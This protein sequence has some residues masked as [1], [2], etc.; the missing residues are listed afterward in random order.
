VIGCRRTSGAVGAAA[1]LQETVICGRCSMVAKGKKSAKRRT[2]A[3]RFGPAGWSYDDWAGVVYPRPKPR[4]FDPLQALATYFDTIEVNT[5]FYRPQRDSVARSWVQRVAGNP[6]FRFTA[7]LWRRF[8]HQR[9]EAWSKEEVRKV[10]EAFDILMQEQ[11]LG[12][13][14]LQFPWSFRRNDEHREWLDDLTAEFDDYPLVLEVRHASW[15]VPEFY[16]ALVER[17]IGFVNIDQPQ[18]KNSIAPSALATAHIGY[19]RV[20]GRNYQEWFRDSADPHERYNYL[21]TADELEPWAERA[22]QI[23][24]EPGTSDLYVVTN[25]HYRG[26]AVVN[27]LML[28]SMVVG[29]PVPAPPPLFEEYGD[30]L[31][32][33]ALP[34]EAE[35]ST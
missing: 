23:A 9:K 16:A 32:G 5:T 2:A 18:F 14:L 7:K 19:V 8:T 1:G 10:R 4:G 21:Y 11:R 13:V 6:D 3:I 27:A 22:Q 15:N 29:H 34:G 30:I 33:Y 25:N 24:A 20:H 26:K 17:G 12:A 31:D 35:V 28:R